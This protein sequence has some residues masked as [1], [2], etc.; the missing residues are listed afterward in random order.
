MLKGSSSASLLGIWWGKINIQSWL[1]SKVERSLD[2]TACVSPACLHRSKSPAMESWRLICVPSLVALQIP[3]VLDP[4]RGRSSFGPKESQLWLLTMWM[5]L[6]S[7]KI[8]DA[9]KWLWVAVSVERGFGLSR[10]VEGENAAG[11]PHSIESKCM[12]L[13]T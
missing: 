8:A 1:S 6:L 12:E 3:R 10:C 11:E 4:D 13:M 9:S 2:L 7:T 5:Q